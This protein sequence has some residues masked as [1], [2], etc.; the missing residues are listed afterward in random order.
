VTVWT[1]FSPYPFFSP[2]TMH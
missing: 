2:Q 1:D